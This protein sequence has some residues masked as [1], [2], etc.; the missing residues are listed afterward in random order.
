LKDYYL[1][2]RREIQRQAKGYRK[3]HC[4]EILQRVYRW[5]KEHKE[6]YLAGR[7]RID[8]YRRLSIKHRLGMRISR[9]IYHS[10]RANKAGR[11]WETL[12]GYTINDLKK[13]LEAKFV[14]GM[15]WSNLGKWHIDH[16]IPKSFF[17]Y[18]KPEDTE[19]QMC[20]ALD[21]LQPLWAKDNYTKSSK[22]IF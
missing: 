16:K 22:I 2:N 21:N 12:V 19:F 8:A 10:L 13:H 1:K 4:S 5:Q 15:N 3:Q 18:E 9:G 7:R 11:H 17:L 6:K 20:W 14:N